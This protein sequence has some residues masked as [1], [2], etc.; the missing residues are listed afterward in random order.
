M[1]RVTRLFTTISVIILITTAVILLLYFLLIKP[2]SKPL[3]SNESP[4]ITKETSILKTIPSDAVALSYYPNFQVLNKS[5]ISGLSEISKLAD[6]NSAMYR[7]LA[8]AYPYLKDSTSVIS[9]HYVAKNT[10]SLL[11][12]SKI[13]DDI[14]IQNA[15]TKFFRADLSYKIRVFDSTSIYTNEFLSATISKG[16]I[17]V[18]SS[19]ILLESSLRHLK[20]GISIYENEVFKELFLRDTPELNS[21][22]INHSQIGKLF[23]GLASRQYWGYADFFQNFSTW[24]RIQ[25]TSKST[26][27]KGDIDFINK[28]GV[29]NFSSVYRN[30]KGGK[31]RA[32]EILPG[33]T[34]FL[35]SYTTKDAVVLFK[36]YREFL[37][38]KNKLNESYYKDVEKWFRKMNPQEVVTALVKTPDGYKWVTL[39]RTKILF[40]VPRWYRSITGREHPPIKILEYNNRGYISTLFGKLYA[41]TKEDFYCKKEEWTIIGPKD[42]VEIVSQ[43]RGFDFNL[44]RSLKG[45]SAWSRINKSGVIFTSIINVSE[46]QLLSVSPFKEEIQEYLLNNFKNP[47]NRFLSFQ[48][49][50]S[51]DISCSIMLNAQRIK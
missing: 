7:F 40:K 26:F 45:S 4:T 47:A 32:Y 20:S 23:S 5:F 29:G 33:S 18:S 24:S 51:E 38:F 39:L 12:T 3:K 25:T 35:A 37:K 30:I 44:E 2:Y 31:F 50:N 9:L 34:L 1:N 6:Q 16:F 43:N 14:T 19:E 41:N 8:Y 11:F 36:S 48:V 22:F 27:I 15:L 28:K 21:I 13:G 46:D 49:T 17:I 42:V 10:I